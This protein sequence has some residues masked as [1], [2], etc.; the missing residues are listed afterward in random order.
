[1]TESII[2]TTTRSRVAA[3]AIRDRKDFRTGGAFYGEETGRLSQW[4]SGLLDG[5]DYDQF[6][7]DMRFVDY[8][9]WSY[10]TPIAWHW[11]NERSGESGWHVVA[12]K[13]SS[14][15]SKHQSNLYLIP[16]EQTEAEQTEVYAALNP[17]S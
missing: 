7:I 5:P 9:V 16:R 1:M 4:N 11:T 8:V 17:H 10:S 2:R 14:T 3:E 13:F 12:Q 15:T 6:V